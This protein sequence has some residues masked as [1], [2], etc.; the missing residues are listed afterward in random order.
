MVWSASGGGGGGCENTIPIDARRPLTKSS[1][2][3]GGGGGG[4]VIISLRPNAEL[5]LERVVTAAPATAEGRNKKR[6]YVAAPAE[7]SI[8][9]PTITDSSSA[10]T[11]EKHCNIGAMSQPSAGYCGC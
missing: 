4:G 11:R 2:A 5:R 3:D 7:T 6:S 9:P 8:P 10:S 1:K